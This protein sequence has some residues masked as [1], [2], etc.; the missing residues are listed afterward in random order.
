M[1]RRFFTSLAFVF[2]VSFSFTGCVD[3]IDLSPDPSCG[4]SIDFIIGV[5][6]EGA[7]SVT[8]SEYVNS[9]GLN[10]LMPFQV[11]QFTA[12][13][14]EGYQF[15]EWDLTPLADAYIN[16]LSLVPCDLSATLT[17]VRVTAVFE[18]IEE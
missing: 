10:G 18:L 9:E 3:E 5:S 14:N 8:K 17:T 16:P 13:P 15:K 4:R 1:L 7:G 6:P 12:I 11:I 2:L